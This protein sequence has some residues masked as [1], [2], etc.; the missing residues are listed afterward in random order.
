MG[1]W[2]GAAAVRSARLCVCAPFSFPLRDP[3]PDPSPSGPVE[4]GSKPR[5][6]FEKSLELQG[7]WA[8]GETHNSHRRV[9]GVEKDPEERGVGETGGPGSEPG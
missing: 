2:G 9:M 3:T 4:E 5:V 1:G 7:E 8:K 6:A